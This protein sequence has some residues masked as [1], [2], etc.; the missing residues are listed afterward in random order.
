[1][2][3][4]SPGQCERDDL[5]GHGFPFFLFLVGVAIPL[6]ISNLLAKGDLALKLW[7]HILV[8]SLSLVALGLLI[9]NGRQ[10][11]PQLAGIKYGWWNI[12]MFVGAILFWNVYPRSETKNSLYRILKYIGLSLIIVL[13]L[14]YRRRGVDGQVAW[15]NLTNWAILGAIGW[16][17][18]SVCLLYI[19]F[20]KNRWTPIISL[21]LLCALTV[22][23]KH[24]LGN[25]LRQSPS[26]LW[27]FGT[28]ALASITMAGLVTSQIFLDGT[29]AVTFREKARCGLIYSAILLLAGWWLTPWGISKIRATPS[30]CLYCAGASTLCVLALYW[31][32]DVKRLTR[33]ANFIRP[34]GSNI[35]LT[36]LLTDVFYAT[37]GLYCFVCLN[38]RRMAGCIEIPIVHC[39]HT[40]LDRRSDPA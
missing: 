30:W 39:I 19:P 20:R 27:P 26:I 15:L 7:K 33:W 37:F 28:G 16:A 3:L 1:M 21:F 13:L 8:R 23:S 22:C 36:Y 6:S 4:P 11:D 32:A 29:F 17:F 24:G 9:M 31:L 10:L 25:F 35:L 40:G 38:G 12:L 18:L 34:A 2:D 5:C 14:L